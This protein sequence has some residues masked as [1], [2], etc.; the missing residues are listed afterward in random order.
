MTCTEIHKLLDT[1]EG[2]FTT[3]LSSNYYIA[4]PLLY[5][6]SGNVYIVQY[7]GGHILRRQK[8]FLPST[9]LYSKCNVF[10]FHGTCTFFSKAFSIARMVWLVS[11]I[12]ADSKA[13]ILDL[14]L[15]NMYRFVRF[16]TSKLKYL[17]KTVSYKVCKIQRF[18][19][20]LAWKE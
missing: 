19:D 12:T 2:L 5:I 20:F 4:T 14:W 9:C 10:K 13:Y 17:G 15:R 16:V 6:Y 8:K 11:L 7:R 3:F 1:P 18:W